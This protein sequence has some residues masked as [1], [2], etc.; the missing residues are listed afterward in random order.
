MD[1][2]LN[3]EKTLRSQREI[4]FDSTVF[5]FNLSFESINQLL[6]DLF[7]NEGEIT[8]AQIRLD[9]QFRWLEF[10]QP[11]QQL[12]EIKEKLID[13]F[14][15]LMEDKNIY[16]SQLKYLD[17]PFDPNNPRCLEFTYHT[18]FPHTSLDE[19]RRRTKNIFNIPERK[20]N[21]IEDCLLYSGLKRNPSFYI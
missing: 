9:I 17:E 7:N 19:T 3:D 11:L 6:V 16:L 12:K 18:P 10:K 2:I 4:K 14:N 13:Q 8:G 1:L 21:I 5:L 15:Y 20:S